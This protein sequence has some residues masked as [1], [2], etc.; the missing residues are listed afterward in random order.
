MEFMAAVPG[1]KHAFDLDNSQRLN[2]SELR[3]F[4]LSV[5]QRIIRYDY[6][7]FDY[8]EGVQVKSVHNDV[9][10]SQYS[11]YPTA[12]PDHREF[13]NE[14]KLTI[15]LQN[16]DHLNNDTIQEAIR[17]NLIHC[18]KF[19]LQISPF[20]MPKDSVDFSSFPKVFKNVFRSLSKRLS[21]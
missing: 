8:C 4:A 10:H 1:H 5:A 7:L 9:I 15:P 21:D 2:S 14:P 3:S 12:D 16:F 13:S 11:L 19:R 18:P 6:N 20:T 17:Q